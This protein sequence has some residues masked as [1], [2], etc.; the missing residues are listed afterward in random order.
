MAL[1]FCSRFR[2][3]GPWK[4]SSLFR[5]PLSFGAAMASSSADRMAASMTPEIV[6]LA[7][8]TEEPDSDKE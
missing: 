7:I 6:T 5:S 4:F 3:V 1:P 8:D 2:T